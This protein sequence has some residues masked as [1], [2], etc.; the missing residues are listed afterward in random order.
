[1]HSKVVSVSIFFQE[2]SNKQKI[3]ELRRKMNEIASSEWSQI[4]VKVLFFQNAI[5]Y[6]AQLDKHL[7]FCCCFVELK[8]GHIDVFY[9]FL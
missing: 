7:T 2:L 4:L 6:V 1:M 5:P 9:F 8:F 3:K